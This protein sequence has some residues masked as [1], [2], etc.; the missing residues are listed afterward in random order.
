[1]A[2]PV[3]RWKSERQHLVFT[4]NGNDTA[5]DVDGVEVNRQKYAAQLHSDSLGMLM[6]YQGLLRSLQI[7]RKSLSPAEVSQIYTLEGAKK[8]GFAECSRYAEQFNP[9]KVSPIRPSLP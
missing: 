7:Y 1:M 4:W 8:K 5:I 2:K 6:G 3:F 9:V